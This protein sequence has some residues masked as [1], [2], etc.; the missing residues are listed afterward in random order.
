R[1]PLYRASAN[2]HAEIVQ[3]LLERS[4]DIKA[5]DSDGQTPLHRASS[6]GHADSGSAKIPEAS[7]PVSIVLGIFQVL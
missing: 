1:T 3:L 4:A 5:A 7:I 6:N 2:G